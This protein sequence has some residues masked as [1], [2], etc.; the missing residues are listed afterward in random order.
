MV[1]EVEYFTTKHMV[2]YLQTTHTP[3]GTVTPLSRNP[4]KVPLAGHTSWQGLQYIANT[5]IS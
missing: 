1:C 4:V 5:I 2:F 3:L